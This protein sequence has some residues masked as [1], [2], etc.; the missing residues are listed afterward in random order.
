M[1]MMFDED[2]VID[3]VTEFVY[4]Q[5]SSGEINDAIKNTIKDKI[6]YSLEAK[7]E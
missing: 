4:S 1:T 2:E 7:S 5:M 3:E 6:R